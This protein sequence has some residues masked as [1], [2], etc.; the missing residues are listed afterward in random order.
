MAKAPDFNEMFR[1]LVL[2]GIAN[3]AVTEVSNARKKHGPNTDLADGDIGQGGT[4]LQS[5]G[6][7][8]IGGRRITNAAVEEQAQHTN[9]SACAD[10]RKHTRAGILFEEFA[11][12]V[13]ADDASALRLELIQVIAMA[14]DWVADLDQRSVADEVDA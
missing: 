2:M 12:A 10:G 11:E 7:P 3:E 5:M 14:L 1:P 8:L 13:A 4:F 6:I 9:D